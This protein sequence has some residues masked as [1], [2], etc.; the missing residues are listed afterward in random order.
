M[1][2]QRIALTL[3]L[4]EPDITKPV[5]SAVY[6]TTDQNRSGKS[7]MNQSPLIM[8]I[9][10]A[11]KPTEELAGIHPNGD[12]SDNC[13]IVRGWQRAGALVPYLAPAVGNAA[14]PKL[15]RPIHLMAANREAPGADPKEKSLREE[16]TLSALS[17]AIKV[18]LD[19]SCG[20]GMETK[21]A[22]IAM[23]QE[24]P[25]LIAWDHNKIV[26][27]SRQIS[28]D[29]AIPGEWPGSRFDM[30]FVFRAKAGGGYDFEQVPQMLLPGDFEDL[31]PA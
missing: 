19:V 16:Q 21:A 14:N 29:P 17:D 15:A 24:G 4:M 26:E 22:Q 31:F 11:E 23:E 18:P 10:H 7:N 8:I 12:Q 13:L 6:W 9:R 28:D 3:Q 2:I 5:S 30:V 20:K 1:S 27:L 25:V